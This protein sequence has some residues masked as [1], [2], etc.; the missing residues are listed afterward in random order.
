MDANL[1]C[2]PFGRGPWV[3]FG[4]CSGAVMVLRDIARAFTALGLAVIGLAVLIVM[5]VEA[6]RFVLA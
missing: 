5:F 3:G 6:V 2:V 1:R 4:A